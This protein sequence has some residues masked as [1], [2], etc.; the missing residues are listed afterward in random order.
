MR[1]A[2]VRFLPVQTAWASDYYLCRHIYLIRTTEFSLLLLYWPTY[3]GLQSFI[4]LLHK[5]ALP[6]TPGLLYLPLYP[7]IS[8][9]ESQVISPTLQK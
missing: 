7:T 1:L 3:A 4:V 2:W 6:Q 8:P 9:Y 5:Q